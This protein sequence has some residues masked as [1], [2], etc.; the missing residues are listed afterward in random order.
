METK[1]VKALD[2]WKEIL[3]KEAYNICIVSGTEA[4]FSGAYNKHNELGI[5]ACICCNNE[6]FSSKH[7]YDSGSGWPSFFNIKKED[8]T[9]GKE[10]LSL[11]INRIEVTCKRCD[12][13]LGHIFKDGPKPTGFRYCINS[14]ALNFKPR[15]EI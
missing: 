13:H 12:A 10:D 3:S 5:Y 7:K 11:G 2:E 1:V 15:K 14:G 8:A 6:L 4:P 9:E